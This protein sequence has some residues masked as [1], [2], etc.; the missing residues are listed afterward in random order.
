MKAAMTHPLNFAF[1]VPFHPDVAEKQMIRAAQ[2]WA[3]F[4]EAERIRD[5]KR[6][7]EFAASLIRRKEKLRRAIGAEHFFALQQFKQALQLEAIKQRNPVK[8][9][10]EVR[11]DRVRKQTRR[12]KQFLTDRGLS[13]DKVSTAVTQVFEGIS[14]PFDTKIV[15]EITDGVSLPPGPHSFKTFTPPYMGFG[16]GYSEGASGFTFEHDNFIDLEVGQVGLAIRFDDRD[17]REHEYA[18]MRRSSMVAFWFEA[19]VTGI[20]EV[21]TDYQCIQARFKLTV[22]DKWGFSNAKVTQK[23]LLSMQVVHPNIFDPTFTLAGQMTYDGDSNVFL[24]HRHLPGGHK[25]QTRMSSNG[26]INAGEMVLVAVGCRSE[27]EAHSNDMEVHSES[28]FAWFI[29][30]VQVRI[31]E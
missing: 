4:E 21:V 27:D 20:V 15:G 14:F 30:R 6:A 17:V 16:T 24:D 11:A 1:R 12:V 23:H 3:D 7:R 22:E 31:L 9:T 25:I 10:S 13:A 8:I 2:L 5:E 29:P 18:F 28:I 26:A 19:P